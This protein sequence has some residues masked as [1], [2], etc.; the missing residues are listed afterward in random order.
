MTGRIGAIGASFNAA[1]ENEFGP[2]GTAFVRGYRGRDWGGFFQDDWKISPNLTLNLGL[3]Y[4]YYQVPWEVNSLFVLGDNRSIIDTHIDPSL[5]DTPLQ[6]GRV[7]PAF[8]NQL[9][10]DD[11]NNFSPVIGFSWDP[12]GNNKTAARGSYRVSYDH[13]FSRSLSYIDGSQPG[14]QTTGTERGQ[15]L[16]GINGIVNAFGDPMS[17]RLSNLIP[18]QLHDGLG[19]TTGSASGVIDIASLVDVRATQVPL[20]LLPNTRQSLSPDDFEKN[21][22]QPYSQSWSLGIQHE[23]MEN[24]VLEAR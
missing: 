17:P 12:F 24:T 20:S 19:G 11:Y 13:I 14:V 9:F 21:L 10:D 22:V 5:P 2:L 23:I 8:G 6:F 18:T 3:R 1:N 7:G 4:D 16:I 15:D